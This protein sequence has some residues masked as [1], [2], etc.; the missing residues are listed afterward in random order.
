M[1]KVTNQDI[2]N[3]L[4]KK[5]STIEG[6]SSRHQELLELCKLGAMCKKNDIDL[7]KLTKLIEIQEAVKGTVK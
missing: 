5:K 1:K 3:Y 2:A 4:N 6:W 7:N